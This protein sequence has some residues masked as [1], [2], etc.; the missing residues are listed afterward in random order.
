[1]STQTQAAAPKTREYGL[2]SG[3]VEIRTQT[4]TNGDTQVEE[5]QIRGYAIVFEQRADMGWYDE[6]VD[7]SALTQ[8]KLDKMDIRFVLNHN[9]DI[10]LARHRPD[11]TGTMQVGI[12]EVG[13]WYRFTPPKSRPDIAEMVERGDV[14]ECS[15]RFVVEEQDWTHRT[16]ERSKRNITS[17]ESIS[18]FCLAT[19]PAYTQTS[20]EYRAKMDAIKASESYQKSTGRL[21]ADR[22]SRELDLLAVTL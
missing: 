2:S 13:V 16:G 14:S 21:D 11:G 19:Y 1:M 4:V 10:V 3:K 8:Q 20:S 9:P 17:I 6:Y 15:F 12:D 7:R 22:R 18:D 5:K